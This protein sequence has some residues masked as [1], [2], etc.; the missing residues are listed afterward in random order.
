MEVAL[1]LLPSNVV[2]GLSHGQLQISQGKGGMWMGKHI[3][4]DKPSLVR[5]KPAG[6][7]KWKQDVLC[8]QDS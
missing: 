4:L 1:V 8:G 6:V 5:E 3:A 7:V 2:S